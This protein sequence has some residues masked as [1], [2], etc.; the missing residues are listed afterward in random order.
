MLCLAGPSRWVRVT[1]SVRLH[2]PTERSVMN[3]HNARHALS[4]V[5]LSCASGANAEVIDKIA[6]IEQLWVTDA[7]I[8]MVA[9]LVT[10][11]L[12]ARFLPAAAMTLLAGAFAWPPVIPAEFLSEAT[13]HYGSLYAAHAEAAALMV[14]TAVVAAFALRRLALGRSQP[15]SAA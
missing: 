14:P 7:V 10:Y 8:A 12:S 11:A 2:S 15:K 5:L 4:L 13:A 9:A 6:S 1:S 3:V